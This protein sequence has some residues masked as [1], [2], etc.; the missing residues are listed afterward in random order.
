MS[1]LVLNQISCALQRIQLL[2][3]PSDSLPKTKRE[4]ERLLA[5]FAPEGDATMTTNGYY[6]VSERDSNLWG[7]PAGDVCGKDT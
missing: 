5:I 4:Q 7:P 6:P 1:V 3:I 2:I